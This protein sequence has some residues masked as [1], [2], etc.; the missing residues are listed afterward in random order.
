MEGSSST[1]DTEI[2]DETSTDSKNRNAVKNDAKSKEAQK[3][4]KEVLKLGL[5]ML[6]QMTML[7]F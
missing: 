6:Q 1:D 5:H 7:I 2:K 4:K 3:N